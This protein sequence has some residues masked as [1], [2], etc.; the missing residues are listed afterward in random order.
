[1][2]ATYMRHRRARTITTPAPQA[3][4]YNHYLPAVRSEWV[5]IWD[6]DEF[7][8][9]PN[10][11]VGSHLRSLPLTTRQVCL[12]WVVF[13]SGGA[14][15]QPACVTAAN[16][17]RACMSDSM[18]K[19]VQRTAQIETA[20]IH[21]SVMKGE[22]YARRKA[23]GCTCGDGR[24]C[25]KRQGSTCSAAS[26]ACDAVKEHTFAQ[27]N[28]LRLHHYISQ[29]KA[30]MQRRSQAG[31]ADLY[32]RVRSKA[33]WRMLEAVYINRVQDTSLAERSVC[34]TWAATAQ[35]TN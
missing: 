31:E 2:R 34:R 8:F 33:Y 5:A 22:T 21:R 20:Q 7:V 29:S 18:G 28:H 25:S 27:R 12:P 19:C 9:G 15:E 13:G 10:V 26:Q 3:R 4:A 11:T 6:A 24:P 32:K 16:V 35:A 1:M 14:V 17:K 30:H 23:Q